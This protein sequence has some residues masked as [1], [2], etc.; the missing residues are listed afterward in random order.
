MENGGIKNIVLIALVIVLAFFVGSL[1]SDSLKHALIPSLCIVGVFIMLYLGEKSRFLLFYLP[2]V[3]SC[4]PNPMNLP[5]ENLVA[6]G[7][8]VHW[9]V[10]RFLRQVNF[11]W[12]ALAW[13]DVFVLLIS[14]YMLHLYYKRP[15]SIAML[16]L[17]ADTI[18]GKEYYLAFFGVVAY[19]AWSCIP[20]SGE[21]LCQGIK[22]AFYISLAASIIAIFLNVGSGGGDVEGLTESAQH[23]RFSLFVGF[24]QQLFAIVYLTYPLSKILTSFR[25]SAAFAFGVLSVVISGWRNIMVTFVGTVLTYAF[26]KRELTPII[27]GGIF[28]YGGLLYLSSEN[29]L[30]ELPYGMQRTLCVVPGLHVK[31]EIKRETNHSSSWRVT[32]WRWALDPRT[33]Y[34]KDY[35]WGDGFGQSAAYT[36]RRT[37]AL[38]RGSLTAGNQRDFSALGIWHSGFITTLHRMGIVG[39]VLVAARQLIDIFFIYSV[40]NAYRRTPFFPYITIRFAVEIPCYVFFYFNATNPVS[41]YG[42]LPALALLKRLY[43]IAQKDN[44]LTPMFRRVVYVPKAIRE[45]ESEREESHVSTVSV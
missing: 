12:H 5:L 11:R 33:G 8:L 30:E 23:G 28:T 45:I 18:G 29:V 34:I 7:I 24:G 26:F 38:M 21:E 40:L 27:L 43:L 39:L 17:D 25:K 32:M 19:I 13:V 2:A 10:L 41:I 1:A 37:T 31:K 6:C 42:S 3:V 20:F 22:K 36:R 14:L 16:G 44:L 15:S 9:L 4:I 35:V